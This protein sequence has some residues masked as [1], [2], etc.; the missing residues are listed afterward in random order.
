[1]EEW[2]HVRSL[3]SQGLSIRAIA[4]QSGLSRNT[5]RGYL[6]SYRL[7]RYRP[8]PIQPGI[9]EPFQNYL[10]GR[11]AQVPALTAWRLYVEAQDQGFT[12]SYATVRRFVQPLRA[13]QS[14]TA[15]YRFETPPGLQAQVDW[16]FFGRVDLD[17]TRRPL[18]AFIFTLG[19]SRAK[20]VE[21]VTDIS[22]PTFLA[23]H[24][25]AFEYLGGVP[26]EI[27]YD[28]LKSVVLRRAYLVAQS[29]F[30]PLFVDFATYYNFTQRLCAP[31]RAATKG[32][33]EN[34]VKFVRHGFFDGTPFASLQELNRKVQLWCNDVNQRLHGTT[35]VAPI[36]RLEAE[37]L[38][39]IEGRPPY[40]IIQ[41]YERRIS[42]D[43]Y[44]N[45][46]GNRYSVPHTFAGREATL[47]LKGAGFAVEV[48]GQEICHH[49]LVPG[50]GGVIQVAEH[51]AGL[52]AAIRRQNQVRQE[53]LES[54]QSMPSAPDVQRRD[55]A[56]Y[57]T[58]LEGRA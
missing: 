17:G 23:C 14:V 52:L 28:N 2:A 3:H 37:Q 50:T 8:R 33:V 49:T 26:K 48:S 22:T 7:P 57:D 4:E 12:G 21:F 35:H 25:H 19:F 44:V 34:T 13:A 31:Y 16:A 47:R 5:V 9:L 6:R 36:D 43:C 27:L 46:L 41:S 30:N 32:K 42:R 11:I 51:R 1:M 58:L 39:S 53:R 10:R 38:A 55:L 54:F 40:P 20:F 45:F 24:Q 29:Q 15:V 18:A 56:V